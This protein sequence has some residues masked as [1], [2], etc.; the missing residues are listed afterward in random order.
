MQTSRSAPTAVL[1]RQAVPAGFIRQVAGKVPIQGGSSVEFAAVRP[2]DRTHPSTALRV[3]AKANSWKLQATLPGAIIHDI[4]F[5]TSSVGYAA[6]EA[7]QV[8]KTTN[9]GATWTKV[10]NVGD[11][12]YWYGV[13]ALSAKDV[14][15][16]GFVDASAQEGVIQWSHDGGS[17]WGKVIV[18]YAPGSTRTNLWLG[19][20]R[21]AN[22]K[23]GLI[24]SL[25][26]PTTSYYTVDGGPTSPDWTSVWVDPSGSG[27]D[28]GWLGP[29]F[30]L[31]G[32]YARASGTGYCSSKN[33]GA[34][35][36]CG[37]SVDSVFDGPLFFS[38]DGAGWVGGGEIS[39]SVAG[40]VHR[41]TDGGKT[42]SGRTLQSP[43]PIRELLFIS[44]D[45]GWAAGGNYN[46]IGGIYFSSD[47]GKTWTL[48]L[49]TNGHEMGACASKKVPKGYQVWCAGFASASSGWNSTVYTTLY[50]SAQ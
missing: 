3:S 40:W 13:S 34:A 36:N 49:N 42:W 30:S 31:R 19:R 22:E 7:G 12:Y 45:I 26:E 28:E 18:L 37:P 11:P 1:S 46:D 35:W 29:E 41:T 9:G 38:K 10:M 2:M 5:P 27:T 33:G 6:G 50:R 14:V 39:P 20:V 25:Q 17:T 4:A 23:D 43:I 8:W 47:G 15:V 24:L 21:F 44:P 16:S 32:K 48:D